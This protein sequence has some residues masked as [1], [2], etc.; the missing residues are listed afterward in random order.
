MLNKFVL[1]VALI[2]LL[3]VS[4]CKKDEPAQGEYA[5]YNQFIQQVL[6]SE[7]WYLW[8]ETVPDVN[9]NQAMTPDVY[10]DYLRNSQ[11]D[12]WSYVTSLQQHN[13]YYEEGKYIGLGMGFMWDA[14][15]KLRASYVFTNSPA[16]KAGIGRSTEIYSINNK[17]ISSFSTTTAISDALGPAAD[18]F[19]LNMT[20]VNN[21]VDTLDVTL[22]KTS[23]Y[24][25]SVLYS[26]ILEKDGVKAGYLVLKG[27]INPTKDELT[28]VFTQFKSEGVKNLII[29]LRYNGG[30]RLDVSQ[31]LAS[32]IAGP[33]ANGKTY[34]GILHN[35]TKSKFDTIFKFTT[36]PQALEVEHLVVLSSQGTASAS[37]CLINGLMPHIDVKLVGE[38][39]HGKPVGMYSFTIDDFVLVPICFR[40]VNSEGYG[41]Y[42]DGLPVDASVRDGVE[43]PFGNLNEPA[44]GEAMHYLVTGSFTNISFAK[45]QKV[46]NENLKGLNAEI[47]A[48]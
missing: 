36:E 21:G 10:L 13:A 46:F 40:L 44:L 8:Y 12:K 19:T 25:N 39:T 24:Q 2:A 29:D 4:S 14:S 22:T 11:Y 3:F 35:N 38:K 27:F 42:F 41:E 28:Q 47:G 43:F 6:K 26:Q 9:P 17:L 15:N 31:Y 16:Q 20:I 1:S 34:Q 37:E 32:L 48:W 23:V 33:S 30:G 18:G 5:R 7:K 45:T